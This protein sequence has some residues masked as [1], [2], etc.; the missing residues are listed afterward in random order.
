M[1]LLWS[2]LAATPAFARN[3]DGTLGFL[4]LPNNGVPAMLAESREFIAEAQGEAT[5]TLE[6]ATGP[7]PIAVTW[8]PA[9]GGRQRGA[10]T[11]P[12]GIV[13]G[14]YALKATHAGGEDTNTR[15]VAV[16]PPQENVYAI[17]HL[18]DTHIGSRRHKRES[19]DILRDVLAAINQSG[20]LFC[21][22][23]GDLTENGEGWQFRD[24]LKTLDT[25]AIPTL[26]APGNHDRKELHYER[27]FGTLT[28]AFAYGRDGYLSF[29][30]KDFFTAPD[31]GPQ[32]GELEVARRSIKAARWSI[33]F[34]HRYEDLQGM[35]GQLV[36]FVDN[37][38][39]YLLFGH[40]HT[41]NTAEQ[42]TVPWGRTRISVVPAGINGKFRMIDVTP[43]GLLFRPVESPASI[44]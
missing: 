20:A 42:R 11:L 22:V 18:S 23:T 26:V 25:C 29:D 15:A 43:Q 16:L 10:C 27:A 32:P 24:F 30:S 13:P 19:M 14:L 8:K 6:G 17:A 36:L 33:G 12:E 28:Y 4:L 41:E 1:A 5:L 7:M 40:W 44:E 31:L 37:P 2:I 35:R 3:D 38:L 21:L 34:S 9:P 39:D